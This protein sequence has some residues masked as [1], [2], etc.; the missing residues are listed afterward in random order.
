MKPIRSLPTDRGQGL[1]NAILDC[2]QLLQQ[3]N[4]LPSLTPSSLADAIK[5]YEKEV[6]ARGNEVVLSNLQNSLDVHNWDRLM[7]SFIVKYSVQQ[8][9]PE[10]EV[11]QATRRMK[12]QVKIAAS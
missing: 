12:E 5:C 3:I 2:A 11:E 6:V 7:E 9:V 10:E 1:N 4:A 8:A